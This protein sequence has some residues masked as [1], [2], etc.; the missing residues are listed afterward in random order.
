MS[1]DIECVVVG[2]GVVG[3]AIARS[4]AAA[5]RQ[6]LVL[7][8]SASLGSQTSSRNSEVIHAGIYYPEYSLKAELCVVGREHLYNFCQSRHVPHKQCGK[9]IVAADQNQ[10]PSLAA[11]RDKALSNGVQDIIVLGESELHQLEPH[12][13]GVQGLLSP[14]TGIVDSHALM[15]A[16]LGEAESLGC[17]LVCR[18][19]V[20]SVSVQDSEFTV[21]VGGEEPT[22]LRSRLLINCAGLG[23]VDLLQVI[24]K[25]PAGLIPQNR[26]AKGCY[27]KLAG[28]APFRHL[29]YPVPETG[30][31]GIHLTLD[32]AGN[33]RFGPDVE[34]V[35]ELDYAVPWQRL[36]KFV[37]GIKTYW[38]DLPENALAPDYAGV[39]PKV[40]YGAS[41][42]PDFLIQ[43]PTEHGIAKLVAL[44][45]IESPGLTASLAIA[46]HVRHLLAA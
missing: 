23:A 30:G 6:T 38:P 44:S 5:G 40:G 29:I 17:E 3:L 11:I 22:T 26:Y 14:S 20:T 9:V 33:A 19:P 15:L 28:K 45:G 10:V 8:A 1:V 31:L 24:D 13:R 42:Y 46:E 34:W 12:V 37:N 36:E 7:E 35:D 41:V 2:A 43:G 16:L 27:F 18:A 21:Q 32:L 25:F 4:L 39:R